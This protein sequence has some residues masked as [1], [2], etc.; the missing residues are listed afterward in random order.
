M[1][2][3]RITELNYLTSGDERTFVNADVR[4]D[5]RVLTNKY[6]LDTEYG[7]YKGVVQTESGHCVTIPNRYLELEQS[8]NDNIR[9]FS[10]ERSNTDI[11]MNENQKFLL[12]IDSANRK[13]FQLYLSS[14]TTEL[15]EKIL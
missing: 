13:F 15:N 7:D 8:K 9:P 4:L 14:S 3:Y 2:R 5:Y 6:Y 10:T 11:L 12:E 1:S